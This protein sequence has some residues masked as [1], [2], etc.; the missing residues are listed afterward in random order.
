MDRNCL[1]RKRIISLFLTLAVILGVIFM[2]AQASIALASESEIDMAPMAAAPPPNWDIPESG[3]PDYWDIPNGA[4]IR[5]TS[6]AFVGLR[7]D[8]STENAIKLIMPFTF[9]A[10]SVNLKNFQFKIDSDLLPYVK[11]VRAR[12]FLW[13]VEAIPHQWRTGSPV[14][15]EEGVYQFPFYTVNGGLLP[16]LNAGALNQIN[17]PIEIILKD[18]YTTANISQE[19]YVIQMRVNGERRGRPI[20]AEE[21]IGKATV[22]FPTPTTGR[23][24]SNWLN[25]PAIMGASYDHKTNVLR[26]FWRTNPR[27]TYRTASIEGLVWRNKP[28]MLNVIADPAIIEASEQM[29]IYAHTLTGREGPHYIMSKDKMD[30]VFDSVSNPGYRAARITPDNGSVNTVDNYII[31]DYGGV[32]VPIYT[33]ME[34]KI[35]PEHLF[36]DGYHVKAPIKM[37]FT[38]KL[39]SSQRL[40][41]NSSAENFFMLSKTFY[42]PEVNDVFTEDTVITGYTESESSFVRIELPDGSVFTGDSAEDPDSN[43]KYPFSIELKNKDNYL[44]KGMEIKV[45]V[46]EVG[47]TLSNPVIE[48]VN[49]KVTFNQNYQGAPE[50]EVIIA[51]DDKNI[52]NLGDLMPENPTREGY[53]F[54]GWYTNSHLTGEEF[55]KDT[56]IEKSMT[57][58]AKWINEPSVKPVRQ[59]KIV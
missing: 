43:G 4:A 22:V 10:S 15:G 12:S 30:V 13:L 19:P 51:N 3:N 5:N 41:N 32:D 18:G 35:N 50:P 37:F 59:N 2:P 40:I 33:I 24:V 31:Q 52:N 57:V 27:W 29:E 21:S 34:F 9:S 28:Y 47:K 17:V 48:T 54:G 45:Q 53:L 8:G 16:G 46:A 39:D 49:A 56:K 7:Y 38:E 14:S 1:K 6:I 42:L 44:E 23:T 11:E 25:E 36:H 55:T 20:V 58:Y 26:Y